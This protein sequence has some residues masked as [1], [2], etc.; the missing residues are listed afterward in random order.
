MFQVGAT[1]IEEEAIT[2]KIKTTL[3]IKLVEYVFLISFSLGTIFSPTS[4]QMLE[5]NTYKIILRFTGCGLVK[6]NW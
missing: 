4:F 6:K 2:L 3:I 1:G 5:I